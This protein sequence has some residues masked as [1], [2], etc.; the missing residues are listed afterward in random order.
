M[1]KPKVL[2][3][4]DHP[5]SLL[6]LESLLTRTAEENGF[7]MVTAQSGE[8]ALRHVLHQQFA[9]ILL[10]VSMPGMDGFETA[11][12]IHSHPRSASVPIIFV[13]A[14]YADEMNRLKGYQ[15]GAVDYL[16]IP[17]IPQILQ[18]KVLVFVEL[19]KKNLQLQYQTEQ[20]EELNRDLQVQQMRNLKKIN[21]A[22]ETEIIERRQAE[23]RAHGLATR[24]AL[25]GLLNRRSLVEHLE[26]AIARASRQK[27]G[28]AVLFLDMDHFKTI[29][30]T[31]GHDVGDELLIQVAK[32]ISGAV[33]GS[34]IVA[35]LGGDEFVV[36]MESLLSYQD[37]AV[38]AKK[39]VQANTPPCTIGVHSLKTSVSIGISLFPQ[40]GDTVQTLMKNADLAMY[41]AKQQ[42]RGSVQFFHEELN[43][44]LLERIQ[45]EQEMQH[46]LERKEFELYYQPKV[47]ILS[48]QVAGVEALLRWHHPRLELISGADFI[49][50]AADSGQLVTIG[51]WV[52][53]AAC[54][55]A[56]RWR[57]NE[58]GLGKLPIAINI[59]IPQ[60]HGELPG[61]IRRTLHKYG[62]PSPSLQLEITESLL[63]RDLEMATSVLREISE[64]G[65]SI[66]IDDFGT[67]YSSLSVLKAL[68]I[69]ILKIDQSFIR[70]LGKTTSDTAIVAA[71]I[72]MARALALRV[73]A[74]GVETKE[75]LAI[76][77]SLGCDEF[78]GFYFGQPLPADALAQQLLQTKPAHESFGG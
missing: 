74:E 72:N 46:A 31:L 28:L 76:L 2:I 41:H 63:I 38:V 65:I 3:V 71:I 22:L 8:E 69:D 23:E 48:G 30:D 54:E 47:D 40:D 18:N 15:K 77:R 34:D 5:A 58:P 64:S 55:Q 56:R 50:A 37:A 62:I 57:D 42:S 51:E 39:I 1:L 29:N 33:R 66:A 11:E 49:P 75:Q 4:N 52:I 27:K 61:A 20:L 7:D 53:N 43:R 70:D 36:L 21:A 67:G 13:T 25:T 10:D 59:A 60:V 6:A 45:L 12:I 44:R 73:V 19:A 35:R 14:H 24:D 32:R 26:E 78:Q 68:P 9:V 17:V 16:F